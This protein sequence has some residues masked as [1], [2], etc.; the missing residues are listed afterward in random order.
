MKHLLGPTIGF[1]VGVSIMLFRNVIVSFLEKSYE[2]F[3]RYDDGIKTLKFRFKIRPIF[4]V[5]LGLIIS[6][7]SIIGFMSAW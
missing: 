4:I 6:V 5:V 7:F 2:K 1:F 3:P